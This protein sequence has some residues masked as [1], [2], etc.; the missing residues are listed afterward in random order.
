MRS[1]VRSTQIRRN[2]DYSSRV[3][4]WPL[5]RPMT[6]WPAYLGMTSSSCSIANSSNKC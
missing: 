3:G 4:S 6:M 5:M 2:L 1:E